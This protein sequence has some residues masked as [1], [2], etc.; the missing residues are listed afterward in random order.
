M[1]RIL[2]I[3]FFWTL[4]LCTFPLSALSEVIVH[5]MVVPKGERAMLRAETKG[6]FFSRGGE[7]VEFFID[8]KPI[9]RTLSG[10]DGFAFKQ[11]TPVKTGVYHIAAKSGRD[12]GNGLLLSLK[13]G[14][15]IVFVDVEG[16]LLEGPFSKKPRNE[17]QKA[18]K[19][20][21]RRF[22]VV[23]LQSGFASPN[24]IKAWLRENEFI[25]FPVIPWNEGKVFD[26]MNGMGFKIKALIGNP[27]IIESAKKY[28]PIAYSFEEAEDA[29]EV[30]D[31]GEIK[32][33]L[34]E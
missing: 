25:A 32:K 30:K 20:I 23:F 33:K 5:D 3:F 1:T 12:E 26:E 16:S 22:S 14:T 8:G 13:R 27:R 18:V 9:G 21:G 19:E 28:H 10:G 29:I 15:G 31:W 24:T 17:S 34:T 4:L 11:F 7:V 2:E 6:K